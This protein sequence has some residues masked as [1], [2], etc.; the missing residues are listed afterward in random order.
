MFGKIE[1]N[2]EEQEQKKQ[3]IFNV[4]DKKIREIKQKLMILRNKRSIQK[5]E[6]MEEVKTPEQLEDEKENK[7]MAEWKMLK[8]IQSYLMIYAMFDFC[9][10]I[11]M[12]MPTFPE[13]KSISWI[14]FRKVWK[15][16]TADDMSYENLMKVDEFG[17]PKFQGLTFD[18]LNFYLQC[19]NCFMISILSLQ[20]EIF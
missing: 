8:V 10:Q 5:K 19:M 16:E 15:A 17:Q 13:N 11:T 14:G 1:G 12:Q 9:L 20:T 7:N 6:S 2:D 4:I 3:E 18:Y